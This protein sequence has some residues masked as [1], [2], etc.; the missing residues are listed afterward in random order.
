MLNTNT[1]L[2]LEKNDWGELQM[3]RILELNCV[4]VVRARP[5]INILKAELISLGSSQVVTEEELASNLRGKV[6]EV[7]IYIV[8]RYM[9]EQVLAAFSAR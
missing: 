8:F 2:K 5:D 9:W 7:F 4:S 3:C 6:H 1:L